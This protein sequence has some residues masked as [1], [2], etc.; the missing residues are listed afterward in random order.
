[1][2]I[3]KVI[4]LVG[5]LLGL[6]SVS[7]Q[8]FT[9]I[10][11][12]VLK[13]DSVL[14]PYHEVVP[15]SD[16]YTAYDYSV[17]LEYPEYV[18]LTMDEICRIAKLTDSLPSEPQVTAEVGVSRKKGYLDVAFLPVVYRDGTYQKM[19][20]FK[21]N[22][23]RTPKT[24]LRKAV[25]PFSSTGRY[26]AHSVLAQGR[27]VKIGVTTDGVYRM[28]ADFLR[29]M[30]FNDPSR[31]KLYGYGGHVQDEKIDA[32]T[33]FDDLEEVPLYRDGEGLLFYANGLTS[34]TSL[35]YSS[36]ASGYIMGHRINNYARKACYFLTEG[37]A[38]SA[39][40]QTDH[41][42]LTPTY[43]IDDC[44]DVSLYKKEEFAWYQSGRNLYENY[45]Y[46][47]GNQRTY[48]LPVYNPV[49]P[50][51]TV[52]FTANSSS[53]SRVAPS[54]GGQSLSSISISPVPDKYTAAM[55]GS[56][57]Y[58]L[59]DFSGHS[60]DVTLTSTSGVDARLD[61]L[62][63]TYE[64]PL[65]MDAAFL[66]VWDEHNSVVRFTV[67]VKGRSNVVFWR[68]GKRGRPLEEIKLEK[69]EGDLWSYIVSNQED[70]RYV[71]VD[72]DAEFPAPE[73]MEE[74]ANQDL[75]ATPPVDLV[76][77]IPKSGKLQTQAQR[78]AEA[79]ERIDG[80][81]TVVVRA[82][83]IYNEFSSG[84]PDATAY[85]RFM[86]MLYDRAETEEDMPRYL[87]LFGDG[88]WD[89]RMY[90]S[91][92]SGKSM[93]DYLLCYESENSLSHTNSYVME[94][95]F[96]LLDD[97]EGGSLLTNKVDIGVGRFP[98][99]TEADAKVMVDKTID[100]MENKY[101]GSWRNI[102]CVL[103]DDGIEED[104]D[105]NEHVKKANELAKQIESDYPE[106][107]VKRIFWDAYKRETSTTSNTYPGVETDITRQMEEGCLMMNYT[108]HGNPLALSHEYVLENE[109]FSNYNSPKVP[110][111]VTAACDVTPFDMEKENIGETAVLHPVGSALAFYGTT[112]TV[113]TTPNSVMNKYFTRFVLGE[114]ENGRQNTIGDA[115]RL[116]KAN[117]VTSGGST[118]YTANKLHYVLLGDPALRLGKPTLKIIVDSINGQKI[119]EESDFA[120]FTAGSLARVS[121]H[122]ETQDGVKLPDF[123][124][125]LTSTVYDSKS[126]VV[127]LNNAGWASEAFQFQTRDK[128]LYSGRDSVLGG[129]FTM[130]FPVPMD[131]KYS[132]E[133][134]RIAFYAV[135]N[136]LT[137]EANG[138]TEHV[139]VGG[140]GDTFSGDT[141]GPVI[142]AYLNRETFQSG[143]T[144]NA[145]PFFIARLEDESGINTTDNGV[146]HNLELVID[147]DPNQTYSLN[148]YY[149]NDFGEY[150]K[151]T[152][153]FSI[154]ELT[155]GYHTLKFRAWDV[156]NN[157]STVSFDFNVSHNVAPGY[158]EVT[159]TDNPARTQTTFI[160]C[161]D[162]PGT[163][164]EVKLEIFDFTGRALWTHQETSTTS[165]GIT[166]ITWDLNSN[167]GMPLQTGVYLYRASVSTPESKVT[168]K[169]NKIVVLRNK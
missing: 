52:S 42:G 62:K 75:H 127:C 114:N 5:F 23:V 41:T 146:G 149:N 120:Q 60:L 80:L 45:N 137:Q 61:Y 150:N 157:S 36:Q 72:V 82:D 15:L 141:I 57:S 11:W 166:R 138:Y 162:R 31:V 59:D 125:A 30:G 135:S 113:Y 111:W 123:N 51:L 152:V 6:E 91:A 164:A 46:A 39:I 156:M 34:L 118:D 32:D 43:N 106:M 103:G 81:K 140:T 129:S 105:Y 107:E 97:G 8:T 63:L 28:S 112:R 144:V 64:R 121:G 12:D 55:T 54:V 1:M 10:D 151:G 69:K 108:G 53:S 17:K 126:T 29:K 163:Q 35:T 68:L 74:V 115:V 84:T 119:S 142:K 99:T 76:I 165:E 77:I 139:L 160:V 147:D 98:V 89:N 18:R 90:T 58:G 24:V 70:D 136:D 122:V 56:K 145:T 22:I 48:T 101:A 131:I 50:V 21:M 169:A 49:N 161:H 33:D 96:G 104:G 143:Q 37:D 128:I 158:L 27:W 78:L 26:A 87:L 94:D 16:D 130:T 85:R 2:R 47:N 124:G 167:S 66:P 88:V 86:K 71:A 168:S 67:D 102:I 148:S 25:Q 92:L 65:S 9:Y 13:I 73:F 93:D 38:P 79:H 40:S 154:P 3:C 95:Y 110:L 134:G 100:Y 132:G 20:S 116:A 109:D 155:D 4:V 7:G 19:L 44:Y 14:E 153:A 117:L 159:C 133:A 83:Q